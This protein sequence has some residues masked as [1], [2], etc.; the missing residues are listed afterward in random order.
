MA[1][2]TI[3]VSNPGNAPAENVRVSAALPPEA[4][5][6]SATQGGQWK[7]DK[8]KV[9]WTLSDVAA[10]RRDGRSNFAARSPPPGANKLQVMSTAAGDLN[11]MADIVTNVEALADLKLDVSEP[12]GPIAVGDDMVYELHVRNRGTKSA[13]SV[14]VVAYFSEGIEPISA[15]GGTH[16]ISNGVVAFRPLA[17]LAVGGEVVYHIHA[18]AEKN[19]KQMFRTEV[20]CG[21]LGTKL[22]S[23]EEAMIYPNDGGLDSQRATS[24]PIARRPELPAPPAP[25][26]GQ[27]EQLPLRKRDAN[28]PGSGTAK[29]GNARLP[30]KRAAMRSS[31]WSDAC[32]FARPSLPS[33][34]SPL[35]LPHLPLPLRQPA[36]KLPPPKFLRHFGRKLLYSI[37]GLLEWTKGPSFLVPISHEVTYAADWSGCSCRR[38]SR[39]VGRVAGDVAKSSGGAAER[40]PSNRR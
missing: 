5:F 16:D 25:A 38:G 4:K 18:R 2:Y 3:K 13:E 39:V 19:G 29:T 12:A 22:V 37:S 9:I 17:T 10:G 34:R 27:P 21:K 8:A 1:G 6:A 20:E 36:D 7:A 26:P 33:A 24:M 32:G 28:S 35:P 14:G 23:A 11:D 40:R 30:R 31:L 15:D